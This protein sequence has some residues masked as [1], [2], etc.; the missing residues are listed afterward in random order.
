MFNFESPVCTV[1]LASVINSLRYAV[2]FVTTVFICK[3]VSDVI[4][5]TVHNAAFVNN[6]H[7]QRMKDSIILCVFLTEIDSSSTPN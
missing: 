7:N 1:Y 6:M 2:Y 5:S 3:P 4:Q